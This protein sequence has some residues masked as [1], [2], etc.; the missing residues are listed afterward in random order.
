[1]ITTYEE[2]KSY[3]PVFC[4]RNCEKCTLQ[5]KLDEA[6]EYS[7]IGIEQL[8]SYDDDTISLI[9]GNNERIERRNDDGDDE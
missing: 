3:L 5:L 4:D 8:L 6:E 2:P 9:P 7:S 1:M